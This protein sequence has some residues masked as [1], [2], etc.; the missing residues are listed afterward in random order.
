MVHSAAWVALHRFL[1]QKMITDYWGELWR[2]PVTPLAVVLVLVLLTALLAV[3]AP[4][5]RIC[6]TPITATINEL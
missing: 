2:L 6:S 3:M 4:A 1:F 5:R